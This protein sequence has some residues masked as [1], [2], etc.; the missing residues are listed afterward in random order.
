MAVNVKRENQL[1]HRER[2]LDSTVR[3][4]RRDEKAQK[5]S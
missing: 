2:Q 4:I 3:P 5:L 1:L